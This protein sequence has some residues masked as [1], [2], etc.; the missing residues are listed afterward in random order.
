MQGAQ[1]VTNRWS[2]NDQGKDIGRLQLIYIWRVLKFPIVCFIWAI[3]SLAP[4][5]CFNSNQ[6]LQGH[7][8][9]M[10]KPH[11]GMHNGQSA[12]NPN[13]TNTYDTTLR[14]HTS[15]MSDLIFL[16]HSI[17]YIDPLPPKIGHLQ[18][19]L[20]GKRGSTIKLFTYVKCL[21][22]AAKSNI[23]S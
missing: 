23:I 11:V 9:F 3:C 18:G 20:Q 10:R 1:V 16:G 7:Q 19:C 2:E 4:K 12:R 21:S 8:G 5:V 17:I 15:I 22:P 14:E 6:G 13:Q